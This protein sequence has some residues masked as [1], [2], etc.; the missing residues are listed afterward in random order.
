MIFDYEK[1]L[2]AYLD[3][4]IESSDDDTLFAA[5]YLSG[6][7]TLSISACEEQGVETQDG[8]NDK[9]TESLIGAQKELSPRDRE[10]VF[11][12]WNDAKRCL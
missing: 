3:S 4:L 10:L 7:I 12:L 5:G 6:H 11:N 9:V 1:K 8:V 2:L